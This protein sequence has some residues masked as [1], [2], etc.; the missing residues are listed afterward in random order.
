MQL[1]WQA[2]LP[3]W[4]EAPALSY[5]RLKRVQLDR[6]SWVD[7]CPGWLPG[8]DELMQELASTALWPSGSDACMT[9]WW[10]SRVW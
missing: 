10:S 5:T 6:R 9:R 3:G 4:D 7:H 2:T 1:S 8:A